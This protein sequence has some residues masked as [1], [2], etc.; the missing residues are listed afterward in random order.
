MADTS[1]VE[2]ETLEGS[3]IPPKTIADDYIT[4]ARQSETIGASSS[5]AG[6]GGGPAKDQ[7]AKNPIYPLKVLY[8]KICTLPAEVHDV[9]P[10]AQFE[11]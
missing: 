7:S 9:L 4:P 6:K 2:N 11:K 3:N 10:K 8:C 1:A 5:S